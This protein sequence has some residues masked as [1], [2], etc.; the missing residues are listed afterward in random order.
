MD[1]NNLYWLA[2]LLEGEG[3]F[4]KQTTHPITVSLQMTDKDV[5]VKASK[6]FGVKYWGRHPKRY[7]DNGWKKVYGFQARGARIIPL[8]KQLY[9]LMGDRRKAQIKEMIDS[10]T[11]VAYNPPTNKEAIEMYNMNRNGVSMKSISD[12]TRFSKSRV[13]QIIKVVEAQLA[14]QPPV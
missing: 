9:P 3:S 4:V 5:V 1:S 13:H 8:L 6:F 10:C 12:Q 11:S 14:E 7:K 2:G